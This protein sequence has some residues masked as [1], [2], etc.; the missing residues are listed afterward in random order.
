MPPSPGAAR[1]RATDRARDDRISCA[2]TPMEQRIASAQTSISDRPFAATPSTRAST[3]GEPDRQCANPERVQAEVGAHVSTGT[4][5]NRDKL[6]SERPKR[7]RVVTF[8]VV[9]LACILCSRAVGVFQSATWPAPMTVQIS[10][11]GAAP[12]TVADWRQ[13]RCDNCGGNVLPS[14]IEQKTV[15]IESR[16]DWES[17]KPRRGRPAK[18][19]AEQRSRAGA[20]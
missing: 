9:E 3:S 14:E 17:D 2:C 15:R 13:L 19:L 11:P 10:Q 6:P 4:R 7:A 16:I 1:S 8:F 20:R 12:R 5:A 18:R